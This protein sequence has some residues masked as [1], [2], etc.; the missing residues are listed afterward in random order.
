MLA[1]LPAEWC[2]SIASLAPMYHVYTWSSADVDS[3]IKEP[4]IL[5]VVQIMLLAR[6]EAEPRLPLIPVKSTQEA[7]MRVAHR[8]EQ[9]LWDQV[10]K[11]M[12]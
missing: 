9:V 4:T 5:P 6:D 10:W 11:Y 2:H 1:S 8:S 12:A 3:L 7:V